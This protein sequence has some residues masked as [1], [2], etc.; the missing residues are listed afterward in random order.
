MKKLDVREAVE[1]GID[2]LAVIKAMGGPLVGSVINTV[3]PPGNVGYVNYNLYPDNDG[4]G[5][6]TKCKSELAAGGFPNGITINYLYPNDST[7][8]RLFE[9]I[10]A[11]LANCGITLKGE[12]EP[13]ASVFVDLGNAPEN[14]KAGTW[15]IGQ[16]A[17]F[18]DW[19]GN[20]G[21]TVVQA[22]F[23]GGQCV[24]NTNN[25][26]CYDNPSVNSDITSAEAASSLTTAAT[27]WHAADQQIMKDAVIVPIMSQN[28]A[29]I[30]ST[31]IRGVLPDGSTYQTALYNPNIGGPD[32]GE[33]WIDSA[34]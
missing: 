12:P 29:D 24:V 20:N 23:A 15:D 7:N 9:A 19:Y 25:Y 6:V 34:S 2:K 4:A 27:Y 22:L 31:R 28:F 8:T 16:A 17:W 33:V 21:R 32:L 5:D 11:S 18:P 10:Q 30:A 14:N 26:S 1:Y 3:I 13:G